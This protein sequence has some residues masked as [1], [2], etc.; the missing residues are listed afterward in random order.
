M[1][2]AN[3]H[4]TQ[5]TYAQTRTKYTH[6]H[7]NTTHRAHTNT[8]IKWSEWSEMKFNKDWI[9]LSFSCRLEGG[10][11]EKEAEKDFSKELLHL[12]TAIDITGGRFGLAVPIFFLRGSVPIYFFSFISFFILDAQ[13]TDGQRLRLP[14]PIILVPS[15]NGTESGS[16]PFPP[17]PGLHF[18]KPEIHQG[19]L[20]KKY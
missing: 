10:R 12:L 16:R 4:T 14:I 9:N 3:R 5:T 6:V 20:K 17:E 13:L 7:T 1:H 11:S 2:T 8:T 18:L 15:R 19:N